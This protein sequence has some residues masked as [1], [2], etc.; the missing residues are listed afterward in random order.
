MTGADWLITG[1]GKTD[2]QTMNGK[3]P[4]YLASLAAR[5]GVPVILMS[6]CI[7]DDSPELR[8]HFHAM[9]SLVGGSTTVEKAMARAGALLY[10]ETRQAVRVLRKEE[11]RR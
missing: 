2:R 4:F 6:G 7:A 9:H 1:E 11:G 8:R 3:V 5:H 10:D